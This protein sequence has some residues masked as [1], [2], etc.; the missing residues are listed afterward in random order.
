MVESLL[1]VCSHPDD[2]TF[3]C[4]GTLA[5][6]SGN[7]SGVDVICL[8]C[9]SPER[10]SE[11]I[12][13]SK[14]LTNSEPI[15]WDEKDVSFDKVSIKKLTDIIVEKRPKIV[16]THIPFDY[17]REHNLTY[18]LVK[19]AIEW[20]GHTTMYD[21]PWVV[22]RLLLMEINTLI[23]QPDV[24]VDISNVVEKKKKAIESYKSQLSKFSYDYYKEFNLSKARLRGVQGNCRYAEAF[25]EESLPKNSPFY[26]EKVTES[27]L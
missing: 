2:E 27:F 9:D 1:V 19:E 17:H 20:A 4:G 26:P 16:L 12:T 13:A 5:L 21:D 10:K 11:L 3:G 6:H 7:E 23:P 18:S 25:L 15:I 14:I 22:K 24:L 8:T